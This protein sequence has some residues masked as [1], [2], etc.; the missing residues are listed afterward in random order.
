[1]VWAILIVHYEQD[2]SSQVSEQVLFAFP[3]LERMQ[4]FFSVPRMIV[5]TQS[6]RF[7]TQ[8]HNPVICRPY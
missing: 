5:L 2:K 8:A 3:G 6:L 7:A 1:M 4:L